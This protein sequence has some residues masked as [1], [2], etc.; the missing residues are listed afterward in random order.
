M[1]RKPRRYGYGPLVYDQSGRS[2]GYSL[3]ES[4]T[5]C[6]NY[7]VRFSVFFRVWY[8]GMHNFYFLTGQGQVRLWIDGSKKLTGRSYTGFLEEQKTSV[9]LTEGYHL[10]RIDNIQTSVSWSFDRNLLM[11]S[12][13][14]ACI[15]KQPLSDENLYYKIVI[16]GSEHYAS[17][18]FKKTQRIER[19]FTE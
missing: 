11:V 7:A 19:L 4:F 10:L 14:S 1:N 16:N 13:S 9:Y 12:H 15:S 8:P 5:Y 6:Y 18:A 3:A 17:P 2:I